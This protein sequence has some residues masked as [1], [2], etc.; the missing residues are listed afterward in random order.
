MKEKRSE[1]RR[2]GSVKWIGWLFAVLGVLAF[3]AVFIYADQ[4]LPEKTFRDP[5]RYGEIFT[6]RKDLRTGFV[7]FPPAIPD[8]GMENRPEFY[9]AYW[10]S[11][12][13]PV[14]E[15]FLRCTYSESDFRTELDRLEHYAHELSPDRTSDTYE[16][17]PFHRD[18]RGL[19]SYPAYIAILADNYAYEYALITGEREITYVYFAFCHPGEFRAVPADCL[20]EPFEGYLNR[21]QGMVNIYRFKEHG[22][23]NF[24]YVEYERSAEHFPS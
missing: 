15:V 19:F 5:A 8:S 20:P 22:E 18:E 14:A 12:F 23:K 11:V 17:H 9:Y 6:D 2:K 1:R 21:D 7:V 13:D 24:Y 16:P 4:K 3:L 10:S